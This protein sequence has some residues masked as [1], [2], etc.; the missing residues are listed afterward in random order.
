[1]TTLRDNS[2]KFLF[3][4]YGPIA[5]L[6]NAFSKKVDLAKKERNTLQ[7]IE[8]K[9]ILLQNIQ[10]DP[11]SILTKF[12]VD[13]KVSRKGIIQHYE[14]QHA[15]TTDMSASVYVTKMPQYSKIIDLF[16][17]TLPNYDAKNELANNDR[18]LFKFINNAKEVIN[19]LNDIITQANN[20]LENLDQQRNASN[21]DK[22]TIRDKDFE[23]FQNIIKISTQ[24]IKAIKAFSGSYTR[25]MIFSDNYVN[26]EQKQRLYKEDIIS[27]D[28]PADRLLSI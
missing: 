17:N 25:Y 11:D 9:T 6:K 20:A 3:W 13:K 24:D 15:I 2:K 22:P 27:L 21:I 28:E 12:P 4:A 10:N 18:P 26:T 14:L 1:L 5:E 23:Y 7:I 19:T 16:N 8:N